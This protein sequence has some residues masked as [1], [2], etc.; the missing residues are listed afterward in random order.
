METGRRNDQTA[1]K[2]KKESKRKGEKL[3]KYEGKGKS[4]LK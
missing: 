2:K 1:I 4:K 3:L